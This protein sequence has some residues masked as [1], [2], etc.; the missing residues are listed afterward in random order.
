MQ[1]KIQDFMGH[2]TLQEGQHF[3]DHCLAGNDAAAG[4]V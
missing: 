2:I 3:L 4:G 1:P